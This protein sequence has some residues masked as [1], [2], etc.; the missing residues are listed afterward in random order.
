MNAKYETYLWGTI[1]LLQDLD[2]SISLSTMTWKHHYFRDSQIV[3]GDYFDPLCVSSTKQWLV[4]I[5]P[6]YS[7]CP[8]RKGTFN[9]LNVT[10][11]RLPELSLGNYH[12]EM[13]LFQNNFLICQAKLFFDILKG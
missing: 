5:E 13:R 1:H 7:T 10:R 12:V 6:S 4:S 8:I 3:L 2:Q 11:L 9:V